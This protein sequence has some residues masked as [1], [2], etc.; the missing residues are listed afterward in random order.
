MVISKRTYVSPIGY[1]SSRVTR[2]VIG[3]GLAPDDEIVLLRPSTEMDDNRATQAIRDVKQMLSQVEP[4]IDIDI[5]EIPHDDFEQ[6]VL[7]I[8]DIF[9]DVTGDLIVNLS[10]GARDILLPLTTASHVYNGQVSQF[11]TYSDIDGEVRSIELPDLVVDTPNACF[12]TLLEIDSM[13]GPVSITELTEARDIA[14]STVTRHL[15][16][17]ESRGLVNTWQEGKAKFVEITLSGRLQTRAK[18]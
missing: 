18:A 17:L 9:G 16:Q 13:N 6:A 7:Q 8:C 15:Q 2:S 14:K 12:E 1:D 11:L 4:E 10:G 3:H 5:R